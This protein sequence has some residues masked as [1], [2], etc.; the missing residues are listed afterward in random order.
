MK[1]ILARILG[2]PAFALAVGGLVVLLT[3]CAS[4]KP[5]AITV[6][7]RGW[8]GGEYKLAERHH[9][10][11][12]AGAIGTFP[13]G[14]DCEHGAGLLAI[15][16]ASNAPAA[17]AGLRPGDLIIELNHQPVVDLTSAFATIDHSQPGQSLPLQV[18]RDGVVSDFSVVIGREK[19][20]YSGTFSAS[21][22]PMF[23][24]LN[25]WPKHGFSLIVLGYEPETVKRHQYDSVENTYLRSCGDKNNIQNTE[26]RAWAAIFQVW[27][28][29]TILKQET[30]I[31]P[32]MVPV[33]TSP[34]VAAVEKQ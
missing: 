32:P 26:W 4:S 28:S 8:M 25:L 6:H 18:W 17:R 11:G 3:G 22:P 19:Y 10:F 29:T 33:S 2:G 7:E 20:E 34:V 31:N 21:L 16:I 30:V 24:P 23:R 15:S 27:R 14:L 5:K 9:F 1:N 13:K 12:T